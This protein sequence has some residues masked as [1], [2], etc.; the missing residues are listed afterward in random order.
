MHGWTHS[1]GWGVV[2]LGVGGGQKGEPL[3][4]AFALVSVS[5]E[6]LTEVREG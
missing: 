6:G 2:G 1:Y 5:G 3:A 4:G